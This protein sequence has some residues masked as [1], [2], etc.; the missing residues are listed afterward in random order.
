LYFNDKHGTEIVFPLLNNRD[1]Y[2]YTSLLLYPKRDRQEAG[3]RKGEV[4]GGSDLLRLFR[5]REGGG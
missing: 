1:E 5:G 2:F 3:S 4:E